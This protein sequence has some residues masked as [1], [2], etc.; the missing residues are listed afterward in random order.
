MIRLRLSSL[1]VASLLLALVACATPK[2]VT[3]IAA[4]PLEPA[5]G[6]QVRLDHL[7]VIIDASSSVPEDSMFLE[8][9]AL[10][11]SYVASAP[12][13]DFEAGAVAFG[14]F[15]RSGEPLERFDR[16]KLQAETSQIQHLE[17]GTPLYKVLDEAVEPFSTRKGRAA[18][19]IFSDGVVTDEFGRDV[20]PGRTLASARNLVGAY[21]GVVCFHTV[22]L[23]S[24]ALGGQNLRDLSFVT[25]CGSYRSAAQA[26]S[27][28]QLHAFHREVFLETGARPLPQV[29]A[30]PA[31]VGVAAVLAAAPHGPWSIQFG[32]DS[33]EVTASYGDALDAIAQQVAAAP[34]MRVRIQG[35]TD[36]WG[37]PLYN[38][39]LS[40]RR[41]QATRDALLRSGVEPDRVKVEGL[42]PD[43]P[44]FPN[45]TLASRQANRRTDIEIM[46]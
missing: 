23:G 6:E 18:V 26:G 25:D 8:E 27:E 13:G 24:S 31:G 22:Q 37:D 45:D 35:H 19:V 33:D 34:G 21:D 28:A 12:D 20:A 11:E 16:A 41:A 38:R 43:Q 7:L 44:R 4:R 15:Q 3:P 2:D 29:G 32:F 40:M 36:T 10:V 1:V 5:A 46:P 30:G 42:G 14:G 39:D 9:R 17:E